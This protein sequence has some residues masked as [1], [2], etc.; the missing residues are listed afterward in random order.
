MVMGAR[1]RTCVSAWVSDLREPHCLL[2][3]MGKKES[4]VMLTTDFF[5]F[6]RILVPLCLS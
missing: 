1:G 2:T 3:H 6:K 5:K 4:F